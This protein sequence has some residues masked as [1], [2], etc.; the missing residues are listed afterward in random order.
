MDL[1]PIVVHF[2]IWLLVIYGLIELV[3]VFP[4]AKKWDLLQ[5]KAI[6]LF[7]GFVWTIAALQT[8]ELAE[9]NMRGNPYLDLHEEFAEASYSLFAIIVVIYLLYLVWLYL[10]KRGK[11]LPLLDKLSMV[12]WYLYRYGIIALLALIGI[13]LLTATWAL[14]G[15][16]VYGPDPIAE[17]VFWIFGGK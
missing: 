13:L 7:V 6:M 1:H 3:Q 5:T 11:S 10:D 9:E 17:F 4:F 16:M 2:P 14:W 8:G 15:A 12:C